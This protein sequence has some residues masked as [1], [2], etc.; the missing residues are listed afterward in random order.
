VWPSVKLSA[1]DGGESIDFEKEK[2][3]AIMKVDPPDT[4]VKSEDGS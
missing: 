3:G 2:M 1:S 4:E